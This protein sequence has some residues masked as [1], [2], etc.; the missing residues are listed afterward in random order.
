MTYIDTEGLICSECLENDYSRCTGCGGYFRNEDLFTD[1]S[2][3]D[4]CENCRDPEGG[5]Y[6]DDDC[7]IYAYHSGHPRGL[8]FWGK[9]E[10]DIYLGMELEVDKGG[11]DEEN[12]SE[13][14]DILDD[15][16]AHCEKDGSLSDGFEII[17]QPFTID[18]WHKELKA[19]YAKACGYLIRNGYASHNTCTC[20]LHV[21]V[22]RKG[23]GNTKDKMYATIGKIATVMEMYWPE[24][25]QF[26]RRKNRQ[27][28]SYAAKIDAGIHK[29]V[30]DIPTIIE[31]I[32]KCASSRYFALNL[33]NND[34]IE[35]RLFQ[36]T[37]RIETITA[38]LELVYGLVRMCRESDLDA[39]YSGTGWENLLDTI[40]W[41]CNQGEENPAL[42]DALREYSITRKLISTTT[43]EE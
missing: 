13:V 8:A 42:S 4:Y 25:K 16:H 40:Y 20:G 32:N 10:H 37:L 2:G 21:H 24:F 28:E 41:I 9:D 3:D 43:E 33:T 27:L 30:D 11:K 23:L 39:I 7:Y 14:L 6:E 26:S 15:S 22:S 38:T 12:A 34:T 18:Y 19:R 17:S 35:F 31:K 29:N 36:G 5:D 1:I